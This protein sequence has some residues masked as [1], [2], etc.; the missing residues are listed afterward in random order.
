MNLTRNEDLGSHYLT[1]AIE[2]E[3]IRWAGYERCL[4]DHSWHKR[5]QMVFQEMGLV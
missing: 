1:H 3:R 2:R 4:R 5:F